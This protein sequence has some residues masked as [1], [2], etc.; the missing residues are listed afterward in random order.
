MNAYDVIT[1]RITEQLEKGVVP[2]Q[3][4]WNHT[5]GLPRNLLSQKAYR[6]INVW[7]L[8]SAGYA[9]PYW[10]TYRQAQ[11]LGGHV[12]LGEHGCP[13]VFWKGLERGEETQDGEETAS[14]RV[15]GARLYTVF[16]AQQCELPTRLQ[17]FLTID[18]AIDADTVRQIAACEQILAHIPQRPAIQHEG[19]RAYYR[20]LTDTVHMPE[21]ALFPQAEHYYS[22]LFHELTHSTGHACR[23]NRETLRDL[24][25]FGDTNYS[26]EEL[27]AEMGAAYLCG[28]AGISNETV[29]NS[30]AYLRGWLGRLRN[31]KR[32]L[33]RA[34]SQAQKAADFILGA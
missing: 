22:V 29:D 2:W 18:H 10:L 12:R 28:M 15:P 33:V 9:S 13:V 4:P 34:V 30:A 1:A 24:L 23:L 26:K 20:P 3:Q 8:A 31:D 21:R 5:A 32:L 6:G 17:P 11:E 14:R 16:N 25:A 27:C 19:A 7:L